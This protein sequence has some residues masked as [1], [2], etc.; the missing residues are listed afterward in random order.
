MYIDSH[1]HFWQYHPEK[2]A[3]IDKTM[4]AI[5]RDFMPSDLEPVLHANGVSGCVAVQASQSEE[6]TS[7][8]LECADKNPFI[9]AVVG[10]ADLQGDNVKETLLRFSGHNRFRVYAMSYRVNRTI[11][12][13]VRPSV[14]E[15]KNSSPWG[16]L[17]IFSFLPGNC[18]PP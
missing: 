13:T 12:C 3:W 6:E 9:K 18:L 17:M 14:G 7:F 16:L 4:Q 5:R 1:Q 11:L 8:L 2:D 10:W 15:L